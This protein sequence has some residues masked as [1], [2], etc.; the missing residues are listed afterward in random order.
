MIA[1][2]AARIAELWR[3]YQIG[4]V[5][6]IFGLS[7]FYVFIFLG[8]NI[9]VAQILSHVCGVIFNYF[10][11]TR[12]VFRGVKPSKLSYIG[13]YV[14]NYLVGLTFLSLYHSLTRNPYFAGFLSVLSSSVVNYFVLKL[15]VFRS[16]QR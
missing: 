11:F 8:L 1:P 12:H 16:R 13:S 15:F 9:F 10:T 6:T 7:L 14:A 3:Y 2:H 4:V 5:N